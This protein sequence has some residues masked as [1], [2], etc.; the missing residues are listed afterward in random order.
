VPQKHRRADKHTDKQAL[1]CASESIKTAI[2]DLPSSN[3]SVTQS[4]LPSLFRFNLIEM[5]PI[6]DPTINHLTF[7]WKTFVTVPPR[8]DLGGLTPSLSLTRGACKKKHPILG[9]FKV[10]FLLHL[11]NL[12][13][14]IANMN[15]KFAK[16]CVENRI[17]S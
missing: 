4:L 9:R 13:S 1:Q 11:T 2:T 10:Y 6:P 8:I 7:F 15:S 17:C 16:S 3:N 12:R 14:L 5:S